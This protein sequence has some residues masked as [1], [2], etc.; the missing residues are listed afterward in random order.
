MS[1]W[2]QLRRW[3]R[4]PPGDDSSE[5]PAAAAADI[6][7]D[8][9]VSP[10]H[11]AISLQTRFTNV[12][13]FGLGVLVMSS[14]LLWYY[15]HALARSEATAEATPDRAASAAM[16]LPP[17]GRI[18]PPLIERVLGP[19][20]PL[21]E[22]TSLDE[23]A[24]APWHAAREPEPMREAAART[25]DRRLSGETFVPAG[26][27]SRD[28]A[29]RELHAG[30]SVPGNVSNPSSS[31]KGAR[32][33]LASLLEPT[34]LAAAQA[35]LLPTRRLL[36]P[37]GAFLDCT[38]ETAIDSS[39]PGMTTCVTATDTFGADGSVV[40]IER[41][42]KLIGETRGEVRAGSNRVF[43][44]WTEART[45]GGV[46][47]PLA[48]PGSDALGRAGLPGEVDRHF[49]D[50]FGAAMLISVVDGAVQAA[51]QREARGNAVIVN[52]AGSS[53]VL[54]EV[55]KSTIHIP[56]TVTKRQ[57]DRIAVLVARDLDFRSVYELRP[58]PDR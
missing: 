31:M 10:T 56:P 3:L 16:S 48:S 52:P 17:L 27:R 8:R 30:M 58:A 51:V 2:S 4:L 36:L 24:F 15:K 18:D 7:G 28:A 5:V 34:V 57:G 55:L 39:L 19:A 54:T 46:V 20:P 32:G 45:P 13:A 11:R 1:G 9:G 42:S 25:P 50:R 22:E 14:L 38:L 29:G 41:G 53:E 44:L 47:V 6:A 37:K 21:P 43:V 49:W 23:S 40:L 35:Q 33:E 26:S 12:V